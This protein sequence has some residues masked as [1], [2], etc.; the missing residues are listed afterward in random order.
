MKARI[1]SF[2]EVK[3]KIREVVMELDRRPIGYTV[4]EIA[5]E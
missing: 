5:T 1:I 2:L 4:L 3:D